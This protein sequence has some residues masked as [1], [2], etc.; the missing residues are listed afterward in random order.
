MNVVKTNVMGMKAAESQYAEQFKLKLLYIS[1][2]N[3]YLCRFIKVL[4]V[5]KYK[6]SFL[7]DLYAI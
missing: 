7:C 2:S 3:R 4:F 1:P 5:Y 6:Y